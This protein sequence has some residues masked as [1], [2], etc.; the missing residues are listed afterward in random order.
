MDVVSVHI[1]YAD[2]FAPGCEQLTGKVKTDEPGGADHE[3]RGA[4]SPFVRR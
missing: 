1:V 2:N 3:C 4:A